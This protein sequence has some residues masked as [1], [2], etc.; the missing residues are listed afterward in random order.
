MLQPI[1]IGP[2]KIE[3]PVFL[4]PMTDVTDVPTRQ[5]AMECGASMVVSEMV[6]A[7][8]LVRDSEIS[9]QKMMLAKEQGLHDVQ[10]VGANP[11]NMAAAARINEAAGADII[12]INMGCPVKKVVK[13]FAGSALMKDPE[14][15]EQILTSVVNAVDLPVTLKTRIGWS[16]EMKN[17]P[18]IAKLAEQCGI[19]MLA[20]HGRTRQQMYKG[21]ADW[22]FI[23]NIKEAVSIPVI[24][25]GDINTVDD[26]AEALRLSGCD[27]VMMGRGTYGRPW[28]LKQV[29]A[30]LQDG[31]RLPDPAL[32]E[33]RD[34]ALR[35]ARY[36]Q[37]FYEERHAIHT[38]RRHIGWYTKG[39]PASS[40]FRRSLYNLSNC[41]EVIEATANYYAQCLGEGEAAPT[42]CLTTPTAFTTTKTTTNA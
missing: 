10:I 5:I 21:S 27:G 28:F 35:H 12:D 8:A 37:D 2:H 23:R 6:A 20:V 25:N 36:A 32:W 26:A 14:L 24:V 13:T 17:G 15:V 34:I 4:A 11:E 33:Q 30:F 19:K 29:A 18:E 41:D 38:I 39:L 22:A 1:H 31:V 42:A 16:D 7:E 3:T 40:E 9:K